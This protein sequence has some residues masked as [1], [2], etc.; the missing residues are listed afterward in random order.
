MQGVRCTAG[1]TGE[2]YKMDDPQVT[3][4]VQRAWLPGKDQSIEA[5]RMGKTCQKLQKDNELSLPLG[6][7]TQSDFKVSDQNGYYRRI[8]SDITRIRNQPIT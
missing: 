5:Y 4:E 3:T 7:G 2:V 8:S 1:L 6:E